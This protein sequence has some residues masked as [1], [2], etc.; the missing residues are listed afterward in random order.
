MSVKYATGICLFLIG[1][2]LGCSQTKQ[3]LQPEAVL[4]EKLPVSEYPWF[5]DDSNYVN[6][7]ESIEQSLLYLRTKPAEMK[8]NFGSDTYET[9]HMIN[10]LEKF[11]AF[12]SC[13]PSGDELREF[14]KD[15]YLVFKSKGGNESGE[16]LFTGYYEPFLEGSLTKSDAYKYPVYGIPSDLVSIDLS[17]F[18][19]KY[20]G[21]KI[22]GRYTGKTV[23]PY[24]DRK[25]IETGGILEGKAPVILWVKDR[26]DLFFLQIQ[27]SGKIRLDNGETVNIHYHASNGRPYKSIG[28]YLIDKG[29]IPRSEMSMQRIRAYLNDNPEQIDETLNYN[30]SYV[31][32][33]TEKDGP[34]GCL[35]VRLTPERSVA[36]D[37]RIFPPAGLVYIETEKPVVSESGEISEWIKSYKFVL[38]QDTGGAIRGAGRADIFWGSGDYAEKA[39]GN[40]KHKGSL[41]FL[42]LKPDAYKD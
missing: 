9:E 2:L 24:F 25:E 4:L 34:L 39:A 27:G 29:I 26:I 17:L 23:V 8:F 38:N 31:F 14:I 37:R 18:S 35:N 33:K 36:L 5:V 7:D 41:Y 12:I 40:M 28:A 16:V 21:E 32:F 6:L 3:I 10:S 20:A 1:A 11:K 13:K 30:P 15:N 22:S 19:P 42:V